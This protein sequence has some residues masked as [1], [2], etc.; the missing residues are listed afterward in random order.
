MNIQLQSGNDVTISEMI[1]GKEYNESL[2][3]QVVVGYM[4]AA[5]SGTKKQKSRGEVKGTTA[6]PWKQK[7]S[8]RARAGS[9]RSPLW[10]HGGVTFAAIP[11]DH[12]QKINRKMYRGAILSILSELYRQDRIFIHE[13]FVVE[14]LKTKLLQQKLEEYNLDDVL[15]ITD[16]VDENLFLASRNLNHVDV[17]DVNSINPV[18]LLKHSNVLITLPALKQI[19]EHL[20]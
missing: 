10:R 5:R 13:S 20:S 17:I 7:G 14:T 9:F 4:N 8:G 3:H 6:K 19:E 11:R 1:F 12:S 2:V 18:M 16:T 15:I